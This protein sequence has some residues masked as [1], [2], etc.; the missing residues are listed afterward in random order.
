MREKNKQKT[1][2]QEQKQENVKYRIIVKGSMKVDAEKYP[3]I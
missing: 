2:S 1:L 3:M